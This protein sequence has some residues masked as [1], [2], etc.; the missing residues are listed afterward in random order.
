MNKIPSNGKH[1]S[2][3]DYR[4]L[5]QELQEPAWVI[6]PTTSRFLDANGEAIDQ[7]GFDLSEV[8][9]MDVTDLNKA[10]PDAATWR[11]LT[12]AMKLGDT[13]VYSADLACKSGDLVKVEI[14]LSHQL[15]NGQP[16]FLAVTRSQT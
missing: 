2:S 8:Q 9:R 15:V 5:Y 16:V 3:T 11:A 7:L 14:T 6:D 10:V 13:V 4:R 1:N 12:H